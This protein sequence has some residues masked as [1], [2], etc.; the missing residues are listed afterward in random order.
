M[1][2]QDLDQPAVLYDSLIPADPQRVSPFGRQVRR[3]RAIRRMS[4]LDLAAAAS[5]TPR[6]LSF[7]ETGRSRPGKT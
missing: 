3:W 2:S 7:A 6:H 4:Q 1:N 5:T